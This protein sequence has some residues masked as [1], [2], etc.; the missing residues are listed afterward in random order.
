MTEPKITPLA[1]RLAEENGIDWQSL[2]GTGPDGTIVERD[3]LAFLAKVMAGEVELPPE[4]AETPPPEGIPDLSQVQ[5]AL[6]REGV[7]VGKLVPENLAQEAPPEPPQTAEVEV[8]AEEV[9]EEEAVFE[10]D[11]EA[12]VEEP[13][14]EPVEAAPPAGEPTP[15]F[16]EA[17]DDGWTV[18]EPEAEAAPAWQEPAPE[19]E[20]HEPAP[21]EAPAAEAAPS[22]EPSFEWEVEEAGETSEQ[23]ASELAVDTDE[24]P[25]GEADFL[26]E[27]EIAEEVASSTEPA[28]D[29][30]EEAFVEEISFEETFVEAAP[31]PAAPSEETPELQEAPEPVAEAAAEEAGGVEEAATFEPGEAE[32]DLATE[33]ASAETAAP[34][35][36]GDRDL[37]APA[38]EE[39]TEPQ[40]APAAAAVAFPPAFRR[41][42]DLQAA[43]QAQTDLATAWRQ[44]VPLELLLFRAVDRALAELEVP[45]RPVLGRFEDEAV[46]ALAVQP[47]TDLRDLFNHLRDASEEGDGLVVV[48]LSETPYAEVILPE[49]A[50]IALGRAGLPEELGLLSISGELPTDRTRFLERVA[51]YLERP[52]LLA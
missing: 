35:V 18:I 38:G 40:A 21:W 46:R 6:A 11:F 50:L 32:E 48:D 25:A 28:L 10:V 5:E 33:A 37:A 12:L 27:P 52:I 15:G 51:F 47:A 17:E 31:E 34:A 4:P 8:F 42:V 43:L 9:E 19:P 14:S 1:R 13:V 22:E 44:E 41:A 24:A 7:D 29:E 26:P 20:P 45:M 2:E 36:A 3:I 39:A 16:A 49:R 23:V 30:A